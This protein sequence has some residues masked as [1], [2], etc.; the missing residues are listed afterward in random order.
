MRFGVNGGLASVPLDRQL[1]P[2]PFHDAL[3]AALRSTE[4]G[5]WKWFSSDGYG[6]QYVDC[7]RFEL[8]R[9]TYRMPQVAH[10]KLYAMASEVAAGFGIEAPI[11]LYQAQEDGALNA[12][13]VFVPTEVHIVLRGPV[14]QTL[15]E[16]E[17]RALMGHELA[18]HRLWT[19][20]AGRYHVVE[21]LI[22]HVAGAPQS[23]PSHVQSALRHRR[24]TEIYADRGALVACDDLSAAVGCLVKMT[25]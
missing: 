4:P 12:A 17:L 22:E 19:E 7:V 23:A 8:L 21:T 2:L 14:T 5:L 25:T 16:L 1:R 6:A 13:L 3:C 9:S 11:T 20:D 15:S 18:H 24:W 10:E